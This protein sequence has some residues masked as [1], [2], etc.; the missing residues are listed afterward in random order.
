MSN[1]G[2]WRGGYWV[3]ERIESV[4]TDEKKETLE[5]FLKTALYA[6]KFFNLVF[7]TLQSSSF[8]SGSKILLQYRWTIVKSTLTSF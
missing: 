6:L 1:F 7:T 2:G 4:R 3:F 8:F 5:I